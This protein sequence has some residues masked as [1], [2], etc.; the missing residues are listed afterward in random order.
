M[1]NNWRLVGSSGAW[2]GDKYEN[3]QDLSGTLVLLD[4]CKWYGLK[5]GAIIWE[6]LICH[7]QKFGLYPVCSE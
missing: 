1:K 7:T 2:I 3:R 6:G 5:C 4:N